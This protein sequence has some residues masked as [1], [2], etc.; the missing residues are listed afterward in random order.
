MD[1]ASLNRYTNVFEIENLQSLLKQKDG[2]VQQLQWEISRK[3]NE[4]TYYTTEIS[5]LILKLEKLEQHVAD[6]DIMKTQFEELRQQYDALC[7][8][9]GEKV[10]ENQELH[11]DLQDVKEMYKTQIDELLQQ[12]KNNH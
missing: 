9:Y 10:E 12:N 8:M 11:L 4:R 7:Q 2:E 5:N 6:F 3:E 1:A